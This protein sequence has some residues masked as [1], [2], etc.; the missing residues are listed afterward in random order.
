MLLVPGAARAT[1]AAIR[2][3]NAISV[4]VAEYELRLVLIILTSDVALAHADDFA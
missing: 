2:Y 1:D 4:E 3:R